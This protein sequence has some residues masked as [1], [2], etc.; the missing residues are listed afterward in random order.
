M[1][2]AKHNKTVSGIIA[3]QTYKLIALQSQ[4]VSLV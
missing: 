3:E 4:S 2:C 1:W